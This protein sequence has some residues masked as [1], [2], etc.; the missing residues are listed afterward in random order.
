MLP[1]KAD[2]ILC[3]YVVR[4]VENGSKKINNTPILTVADIIVQKLK[5]S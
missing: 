1:T 5:K 4:Q 2:V 3:F